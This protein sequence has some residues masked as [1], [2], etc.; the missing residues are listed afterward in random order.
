MMSY[1]HITG[2]KG[3]AHVIVHL[4]VSRF[5]VMFVHFR[6]HCYNSLGV[7]RRDVDLFV[8]AVMNKRKSRHSFVSHDN[9]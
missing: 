7:S 1:Q 9:I 6:N 8:Y 4:A 3:E 5:D 2:L